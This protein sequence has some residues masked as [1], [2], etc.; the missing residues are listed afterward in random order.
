MIFTNRKQLSLSFFLFLFLSKLSPFCFAEMTDPL[1]TRITQG[2]VSKIFPEATKLGPPEGDPPYIPVIGKSEE[3]AVDERK[4]A[5]WRIEFLQTNAREPTKKETQDK[6][7]SFKTTGS[8]QT[9]GYLFSTYE[10]TK[11]RGYSGDHFDIISGIRPD[12]RLAGSVIVELHEPM[13]CPTC[14]PQTKLDALYKTFENINVNKRA[15]VNMGDSRG[16]DGVS[17][18]TISA[19][20]TTNAIITGARKVSRMVNVGNNSDNTSPFYLDLDSYKKKSWKELLDWGGI[21]GIKFSK[22]EIVKMLNESGVKLENIIKPNATFLEIY[23]GI[24]TPA[25]IGRNLFG[26]QWYSFHLSKIDAN[27]NL[28]II[29]GSD[30]WSW[31]GNNFRRTNKYDRILLLQEDK[32][33]EFTADEFV[34]PT[35]IRSEGRP[36]ISEIGLFRIPKNWGFDPLKKWTL[37]I[38]I[39][40]EFA[41]GFVDLK[42][43]IPK[44]LITGDQLALE[45]AG[46]RPTKKSFFGLIRQSKLSG[47]KEEWGKEE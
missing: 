28:L 12:G 18:A 20:M 33:F 25:H 30:G 26:D 10:T 40:H 31:K 41:E 5:R 1:Q 39:E 24:A 16:Y 3:I 43:T 32:K 8:Q 35:A 27:E 11:A 45:D 36:K 29:L 7:D 15:K 44:E 13:I 6:I 34:I 17:G 42:Y 21:Q 47:W 2:I 4:M 37:K 46:L 23:A 9:I 22:S 14:V 19:T 38:K